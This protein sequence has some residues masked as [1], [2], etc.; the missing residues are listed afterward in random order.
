MKPLV[1]PKNK[2]TDKKMMKKVTIALLALA[3]VACSSDFI[4]DAPKGAAIEFDN[5]FVENATRATDLTKDNVQDFGVFG[6]VESGS[7]Q[8]QIFKNTRVYR[9]GEGFKYDIPQYWIGGA[10]YY[11]TALAPF[12]GA[13]WSYTP[14]NA[15]NGTIDFDNSAAAAAQ[16]LIFAYVKPAVTPEV[17][18]TKPAAVAFNFKHILARVKFAF[19][20]EF[21][22]DSNITLKVTGVTVT[23]AAKTGSI[24]VVDG[25][26]QSWDAKD[27]MTIEF[28]NTAL[29]NSTDVVMTAG[30]AV[31]SNHLY[32]IPDQRTYNVTFDVTLYQAGVELGHYSRQANVVLNLELGKS[33]ELIAK[34]NPNNTSGNG[35]LEPIEFTVGNIDNWVEENTNNKN[36]MTFANN[37]NAW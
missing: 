13:K 4:V 11:F 33:Y 18:D 15:N 27:N 2:K 28:G 3:T 9:E 12:T 1:A 8:G 29:E 31:K 22:S 34:L 37:G 5:L 14:T 24:D 17:I 26:L 6:F 10:Q 16:D 23:N 20:N 19:K 25:A 36:S 32:L 30:N 21:A 7:K 35:P